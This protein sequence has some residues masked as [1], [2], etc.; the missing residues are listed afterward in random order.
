MMKTTLRRVATAVLA[1]VLAGNTCAYGQSFLKKLGKALDKV[2]AATAPANSS[3]SSNAAT[4]GSKFGTIPNV[5]LTLK[6]CVRWGTDV[7]V[8]FQMTNNNSSDL[9][10]VINRTGDPGPF[11]ECVAVA[12]GGK[13]FE[14][15]PER[16]GTEECYHGSALVSLPAGVPVN[17]VLLVSGVPESVT[18][19]QRLEIGG[20]WR[21]SD[22]K[23]E[24]YVYSCRQAIPITTVKNTNKD[25][26]KCPLPNINVN[27]LGIKRAGANAVATYTLTAQ[28]EMQ[29]GE[30]NKG[31]AYDT[32]GNS[33]D[34]NITY[35]GKPASYSLGLPGG[36]PVKGVMTIYKVP[37]SIKQFSLLR[38]QLADGK[39]IEVR[40][41]PVQ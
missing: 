20:F 40:N 28:Q 10:F 23:N 27:F 9:Q 8:V 19:F 26:V 1:I 17:G 12:E 35:A 38:M 15:D 4:A 6:S 34:F 18:S 22:I 33:Y 7:R 3:S 5:S 30:V 36:V 39:M 13:M 32:E 31:L 21:K 24:G 11:G 29:L 16:F 41:E 2:A 14:C 37:Q 25:N